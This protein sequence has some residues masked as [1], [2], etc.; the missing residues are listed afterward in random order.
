MPALAQNAHAAGNTG[1]N[2]PS[3]LITVER[4][5]RL[6]DGQFTLAEQHQTLAFITGCGS[7]KKST[8]LTGTT[9]DPDYCVKEV[10]LEQ[11]PDLGLPVFWDP[12]TRGTIGVMARG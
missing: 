5:A 3:G 7:G 9:A 11:C 2:K 12:G 6:F 10:D 4:E 1:L 8:V